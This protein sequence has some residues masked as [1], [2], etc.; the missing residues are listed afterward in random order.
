MIA[1]RCPK[2]HVAIQLTR[3]GEDQASI[4]KLDELDH[5]LGLKAIGM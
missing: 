3:F 1:K 2:E 5:G 4:D